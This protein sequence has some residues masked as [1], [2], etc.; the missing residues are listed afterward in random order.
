M[1]PFWAHVLHGAEIEGRAHGLKVTYRS[2]R[3]SGDVA[4]ELRELVVG[5][6]LTGA[7]LVGAPGGDVLGVLDEFGVPIVLVDT[8]LPGHDAVLSDNFG[9]AHAAV[10][11]LIEAGHR[12]VAFIGGP[13]LEGSRHVDA[14][15]SIKWRA[16]GYRIALAEAGVA[17]REELLESCDLTS[18]G[19]YHACRRLLASGALFTAVF[20]GN[21]PTAVGVLR[22]LRDAGREVPRD[23]SVAGFD[24]EL[25]EHTYPALTTVRVDKAEMGA[26]AVRALLQR[27]RYPR[28]DPLT[29][30][31]PVE[32]VRRDS[33]AAPAQERK[34][35]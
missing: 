2:V 5:M 28:A 13:V 1:A 12:D 31:T 33:V 24:D 8:V 14:V 23:V 25:A 4:G 17:V 22:A 9:G 19:G 16:L 10:T 26:V 35:R 27:Q 20:C 30:I 11:H 34:S 29:I 18:D 6:N 7:L 21:D 15:Y 32:L 3:G